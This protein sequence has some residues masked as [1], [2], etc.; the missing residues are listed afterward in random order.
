MIH[1]NDETAKKEVVSRSFLR[2]RKLRQLQLFFIE[3]YYPGNVKLKD[4][5][6]SR[7]I[8]HVLET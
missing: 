7:Y 2:I 8:Y 6:L 5:F 1:F 4:D 3:Q